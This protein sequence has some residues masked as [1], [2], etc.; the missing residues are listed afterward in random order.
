MSDDDGPRIF[1]SD[2]FKD[3]LLVFG[4]SSTNYATSLDCRNTTDLREIG[5]EK[6]AFLELKKSGRCATPTSLRLTK[7]NI[8]SNMAPQHQHRS[9]DSG[10]NFSAMDKSQSAPSLASVAVEFA[11]SQRFSDV[12]RVAS[13]PDLDYYK[14]YDEEDLSGEMSETM[15]ITLEEEAR[16]EPESKTVRTQELPMSRSQI[17]A[18]NDPPKCEEEDDETRPVMEEKPVTSTVRTQDRIES[19]LEMVLDNDL[20]QE[21]VSSLAREVEA[22]KVQRS[23]S[24]RSRKVR[25]NASYELAQQLEVD[26]RAAKSLR[27]EDGPKPTPRKKMANNASYELAQQCDYIRVLQSKSFRRM[28]AC[29]EEEEYSRSTGN[30]ARRQNQA[31]TYSKSTEN[32]SQGGLIGQIKKNSDLFSLYGDNGRPLSG[33]VED[34]VDF[35]CLETKPIEKSESL[36][37]GRLEEAEGALKGKGM[38][39][40]ERGVQ[41]P[42]ERANDERLSSN[43]TS[44]AQRSAD[45][46]TEAS[47]VR[48]DMS[49]AAAR[50]LAKAD[51]S[52]ASS[53]TTLNSHEK[54]KTGFGGFL[55]RFSKLR[56]SGRSKVPRSEINK[57]VNETKI[58][59]TQVIKSTKKEPDYIII[60][61]HPPEDDRRHDSTNEQNNVR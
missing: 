52:A 44:E 11:A 26:D 17:V 38:P 55:Q 6:D 50:R 19:V 59:Q 30:I 51:S 58:V 3:R 60:P 61:L 54:R 33:P 35:C 7:L 21:L 39:G 42:P 8:T 15:T 13:A 24:G 53:T 48:A 12:R 14:S 43:R 1:D 25:N 20:S 57:P 46:N 4:D 41:S 40:L 28:D 27:K 18:I 10:F 2:S 45:F 36:R 49:A 31:K 32:V 9:D 47:P 23:E 56:F 37:P 5:L 29:E 34:D 16:C 22:V